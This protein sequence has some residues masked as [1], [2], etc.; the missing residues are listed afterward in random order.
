MSKVLA[1][2]TLACLLAFGFVFAVMLGYQI[3]DNQKHIRS[4]DCKVVRVVDGPD[5][6]PVIFDNGQIPRPYTVVANDP[7]YKLFVLPGMAGVVDEPIEVI[8][9]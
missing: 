8:L 2:T 1:A 6:E 5:D 7:K 9:P 3:R 4:I